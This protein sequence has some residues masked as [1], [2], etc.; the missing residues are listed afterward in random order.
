MFIVNILLVF[1]YNIVS[2]IQLY[3]N[4]RAKLNANVI[5]C[6]YKNYIKI[7]RFLKYSHCFILN[8]QI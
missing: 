2:L 6:I 7:L 8:C 1:Y 5:I 3:I 4:I